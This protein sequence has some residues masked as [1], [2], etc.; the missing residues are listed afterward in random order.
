MTQRFLLRPWPGL[1]HS[2]CDTGCEGF[3][4]KSRHHFHWVIPSFYINS[5]WRLDLDGWEA[6]CPW[7]PE[8]RRVEMEFIP[9]REAPETGQKQWQKQCICHSENSGKYNIQLIPSIA[10]HHHVSSKHVLFWSI[11]DMLSISLKRTNINNNHS[12]WNPISK[13]FL[14]LVLNLG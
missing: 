12:C 11:Y 3:R 10:R 8:A 2:L 5:R 14:C 4:F 7:S 1:D 13:D 6:S 9:T